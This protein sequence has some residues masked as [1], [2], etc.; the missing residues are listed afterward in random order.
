MAKNQETAINREIGKLLRQ[1]SIERA[2]FEVK[3]A[4]FN[5]KEYPA[6]CNECMQETPEKFKVIFTRP[7]SR[8]NGDLFDE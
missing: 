1:R 3:V 6:E 7:G 5:P 2:D 8:V 4:D